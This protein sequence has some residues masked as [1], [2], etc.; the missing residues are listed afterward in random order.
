MVR[1]DCRSGEGG[2]ALMQDSTPYFTPTSAPYDFSRELQRMT[3]D[4]VA[5]RERNFSAALFPSLKI[6]IWRRRSE[7]QSR[8]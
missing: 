4:A 6:Y 2:L 8:T 1:N 3:A 7:A 5:Q